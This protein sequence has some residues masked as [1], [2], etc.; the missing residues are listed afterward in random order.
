MK[1]IM[2]IITHDIIYNIMLNS[3]DLI[4]LYQINKNSLQIWNTL[5]FWLDRY[6]SC[7]V[8]GKI[9]TLS[10]YQVY[11]KMMLKAEHMTDITIKIANIEM[12]HSMPALNEYINPNDGSIRVMWQQYHHH[13]NDDDIVPDKLKIAIDDKL[14]KA[15]IEN[16]TKYFPN[17]ILI[18]PI[19]DYY[20]VNYEMLDDEGDDTI[21]ITIIMSLYEVKN[22]LK[23]AYYVSLLTD[24]DVYI[25]DRDEDEYYD[26]DIEYYESAEYNDSSLIKFYMRLGIRNTLKVL[27]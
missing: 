20:E 8:Y 23:D 17:I 22:F 1:S 26:N 12:N 27:T 9:A 19:N 10:E 5:S 14:K 3:N 4:N 2:E 24:K 18:K 21:E 15:I 25:S 7:V 6:K 13:I 11:Y 16:E